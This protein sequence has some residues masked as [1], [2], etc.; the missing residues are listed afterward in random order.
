LRTRTTGGVLGALIHCTIEVVAHGVEE[1]LSGEPLLLIAHEKRQVLGHLAAFYGVDDDF[2]EQERVIDELLI[3]V[4]LAAMGG[5]AL[6]PI[7]SA[8][9]GLRLAHTGA[10]RWL[11]AIGQTTALLLLAATFVFVLLSAEPVAPLLFLLVSLWLAGGLSIWLF[12]VWLVG[13][14]SR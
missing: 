8:W 7:L 10:P 11:M 9:I 1:A 2:L 13:R 3:A 5:I 12:V 14:R 6:L 4:E